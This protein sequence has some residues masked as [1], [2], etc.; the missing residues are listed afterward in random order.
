MD[1]RLWGA[2]VDPFGPQG[3]CLA[4]NVGGT[5]RVVDM[6]VLADDGNLGFP[7]SLLGFPNAAFNSPGLWCPGLGLLDRL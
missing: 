1:R 3:T 2:A 6:D 4:P 7:P 5:E